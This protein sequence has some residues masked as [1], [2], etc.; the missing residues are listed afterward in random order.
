MNIY[1][2]IAKRQKQ[3]PANTFYY[4]PFKQIM[5]MPKFPSGFNVAK[6]MYP[7]FIWN[8]KRIEQTF[9]E[10]NGNWHENCSSVLSIILVCLT[11]TLHIDAWKIYSTT[12]NEIYN[13]P[14]G[15]IY[16]CCQ[17]NR[18]ANVMHFGAKDTLDDETIF[19]KV[20]FVRRCHWFNGKCWEYKQKLLDMCKYAKVKRTHKKWNGSFWEQQCKQKHHPPHVCTVDPE[21]GKKTN[22]P[23]LVNTYKFILSLLIWRHKRQHRYEH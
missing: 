23:H 3:C 7:K 9:A 21:E 13:M 10:K 14:N 4:M 5:Q 16:M 11:L 1:I 15:D 2:R 22:H 12:L 8:E 19:C 17:L 18:R 20:F 6:N